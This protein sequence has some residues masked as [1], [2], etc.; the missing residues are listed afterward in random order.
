MKYRIEF[1]CA[2]FPLDKM[3]IDV[4][5]DERMVVDVSEECFGRGSIIYSGDGRKY[6]FSLYENSDDVAGI[7]W[8]DEGYQAGE[9]HILNKRMVKGESYLFLDMRERANYIITNIVPFS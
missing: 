5:L 1:H 2:A 3:S 7:D 8:K 9:L 4:E 6:D